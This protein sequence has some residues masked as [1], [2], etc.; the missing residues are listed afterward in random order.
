M[1]P[2]QVVSACSDHDLQG[3]LPA[4]E[5]LGAIVLCPYVVNYGRYYSKAHVVNMG[6]ALAS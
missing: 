4:L 2:A 3:I 1:L 6:N 5:S